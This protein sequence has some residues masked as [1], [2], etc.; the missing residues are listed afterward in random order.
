LVHVLQDDLAVD[1]D[2]GDV[3]AAGH[4]VH[5]VEEDLLRVALG[6]GPAEMGRLNSR[7]GVLFPTPVPA[8]AT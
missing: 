5:H 7:D 2:P 4:F 8:A 3:V 1:D 6:S